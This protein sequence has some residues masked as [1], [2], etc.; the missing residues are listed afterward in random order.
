MAFLPGRAGDAGAP[1][2]EQGPCSKRG[3]TAMLALLAEPRAASAEVLH[4]FRVCEL[5]TL[6][7]LKRSNEGFFPYAALGDGEQN[8]PLSS[9]FSDYLL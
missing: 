9:P 5:C 6:S 7:T 2:N 4:Q 3:D 8:I 1:G